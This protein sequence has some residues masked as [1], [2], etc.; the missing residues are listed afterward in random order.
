MFPL[1]CYSTYNFWM[2]VYFP[3]PLISWQTGLFSLFLWKLLRGKDFM[4][5]LYG[6]WSSKFFCHGHEILV[7]TIISSP[8]LSILQWCHCLT[9]PP[10]P[11]AYYL[12][13]SIT[14]TTSYTLCRYCPCLPPL[15]PLLDIIH[16]STSYTIV[17]TL[18]HHH[19]RDYP[20]PSPQMVEHVEWWTVL[21]TGG[22]GY[23]VMW[24]WLRVSC[25]GEGDKWYSI[26]KQ[27]L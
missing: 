21:R 10:S 27:H 17:A 1:Q 20:R 7:L 25:S 18:H 13:P 19:S 26:V 9:S 5:P 14:A 11:L 16:H 2:L 8:S 23:Q 22:G 12:A 4:H 3:F 15:L 6:L 24:R